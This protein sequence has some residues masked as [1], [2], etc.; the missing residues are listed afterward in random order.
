[1]LDLSEV[2]DKS[3]RISPSKGSVFQSSTFLRINREKYQN[4]DQKQQRVTKYVWFTYRYAS[5]INILA[6][7][8]IRSLCHL[9]EFRTPKSNRI[10]YWKDNFNPPEFHSN[11]PGEVAAI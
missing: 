9:I 7:F 4:A 8:S 1:M 5:L 3:S 11:S 6:P 10:G 2:C